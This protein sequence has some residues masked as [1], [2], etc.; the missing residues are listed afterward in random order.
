MKSRE[1]VG[2]D[3]TNVTSTSTFSGQ[4]VLKAKSSQTFT[5]LEEDC[6]D[7]AESSHYHHYHHDHDRNDNEGEDDQSS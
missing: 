5:H 3:D 2:S 1:L 4:D 7:I 6:I